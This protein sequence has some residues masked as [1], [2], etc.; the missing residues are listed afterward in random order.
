[1]LYTWEQAAKVR[2]NALDPSLIMWN[3]GEQAQAQ[4]IIWPPELLH[5]ITFTNLSSKTVRKPRSTLLT[6][7]EAF[8]SLDNCPA[9]SRSL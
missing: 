5:E 4:F 7:A 2:W 8:V 3:A 1:V 9:L 6:M